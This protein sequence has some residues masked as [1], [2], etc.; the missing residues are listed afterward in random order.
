MMV[1]VLPEQFEHG[2]KKGGKGHGGRRGG[3]GVPPGAPR[4]WFKIL[5][6]FVKKKD[7]S[8]EEIHTM[9]EEAGF[10]VPIEFIEKKLSKLRMVSDDDEEENKKEENPK[11]QKRGEFGGMMNHFMNMSSMKKEDV[12]KDQKKQGHHGPFRGQGCHGFGGMMNHFMNMSEM[13]KEDAQKPSDFGGIINH[14]MNMSGMQKEDVQKIATDAGVEMPENAFEGLM[15]G[16]IS[17]L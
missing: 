12:Q 3:H 9:A 11:D 6:N 1:T 8:A 14:F 17:G 15:K 16:D 5:K 13:K 7:V 4:K 2:K 10:K